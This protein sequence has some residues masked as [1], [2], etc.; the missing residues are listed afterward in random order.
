VIELEKL[1]PTCALISKGEYF[2]REVQ[3]GGRLFASEDFE[4]TGEG[5]G[6]DVKKSMK[7]QAA[8]SLKGEIKGVG[9]E[10]GVQGGYGQSSG[11]ERNASQGAMENSLQWQANGGDTL[12][13]NK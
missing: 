1:P 2:S 3:V 6:S 11:T 9:V 13:C 12:L 8:S 5:S 7:I 4:W 10:G